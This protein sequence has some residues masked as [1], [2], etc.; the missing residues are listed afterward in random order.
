MSDVDWRNA[1]AG[2]LDP[3]L[4]VR[5]VK[6]LIGHREHTP[7]TIQAAGEALMR[8]NLAQL[9][10]VTTEMNMQTAAAVSEEYDPWSTD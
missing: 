7:A 10:Q 2:K 4:R 1:P 3:D 5:L 6:F 9:V 8:M